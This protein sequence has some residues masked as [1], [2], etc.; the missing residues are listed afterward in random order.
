[1]ATSPVK[2]ESKRDLAYNQLRRLFI[3]QQI[4]EGQRLRETDWAQRLGVNRPALREALVRLAAEDLIVAGPK[5]GF[6]VPA[7]TPKEFEDIVKVRLVLEGSAIEIICQ[8][9]LNTPEHLKPLIQSCDLF[10]QLIGDEYYLSAAEADH[11]FHE[12]LVE[13]SMNRRLAA[14]YRHAPLPMIHPD[15][16]FGKEW[17]VIERCSLAEHREL[18]EAILQGDTNRAKTCLDEHLRG[19]RQ[20]FGSKLSP[21]PQ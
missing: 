12:T 16:V 5:K 20:P 18:I 7:I 11:R 10:E 2:T 8:S 6:F 1:M 21:P 17:L 14:A 15:V 9:K 3:L 13:L 19:L 4:P